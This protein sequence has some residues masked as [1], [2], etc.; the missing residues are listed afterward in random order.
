MNR[1][2]CSWI[3]WRVLTQLSDINQRQLGCY[4][5]S[6]AFV[7]LQPS[8]LQPFCCSGT[9]RKCLRCSWNSMQ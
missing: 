2:I 4:T 9:L 1:E 8:V 7:I 6:A 5:H 3:T